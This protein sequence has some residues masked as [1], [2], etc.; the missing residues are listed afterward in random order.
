MDNKQLVI[1]PKTKVGEL[2][3]IYPQLED[4]LIGMAPAFEKLKNPILRRTVAKVATLHQVAGIGNLDVDVVV[5]NLRKAVGQSTDS[6]SNGD[7]EYIQNKLPDWVSEGQIVQRF[8]ATI[9]INAGENP[10]QAILKYTNELNAGEIFELTTPFIP[11]PILDI[12]KEKGFT[13]CSVKC[14]DGF[15]NYFVK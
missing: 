1:T 11:A 7:S 6:F 3:D 5:N 13:A 2:L 14:E 9:M 4:I 8:D 15:R 10:M 12:L